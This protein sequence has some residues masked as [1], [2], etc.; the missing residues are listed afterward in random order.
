VVDVDGNEYLDVLNNYTALVHGHAFGPIVDALARAARDGSVHPAPH[1][2][3]LRLA[4]TITQRYPAAELV[5]FTN[6][7]T[8][9]AV[10]AA[11][12]A[13]RATGRQRI[14]MFEG[15]YHGTAPDFVGETADTIRVPYNDLDAVSAV[16]DNRVAAVFAEPFLGS[17]G[18]IAAA[19]GFLRGVEALARSAGAVFVLDEVQSLRSA[20][21]G[22][23]GALGLRPDLLLMGKLIG[24]GLP[25]GA[26]VGRGELLE[27]TAAARRDSL[28]HS[29]TFNG[30]VLT[31]AA[32]EESLRFLDASA[33]ERLNGCAGRLEA[34]IV[35]AADKSG[36]AIETTRSG[37]IIQVHTSGAGRNTDP[38]MAAAL[39][40]A[41]LLE[42][43]YAAPRGMLN[44]STALGEEELRRVADGYRGAFARL[45][46]L[47]EG[48]GAT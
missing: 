44:L 13:R 16:L 35:T 46:A 27:L 7:G 31:C 36:V 34:D 33:I 32:G 3:Q 30:N 9:A 2:R 20:Y 47:R 40:L 6:S 45:G 17:G 12:I 39:H 41:L 26:V 1:A 37:S 42:G 28:L 25:V 18:V 29:G 10:L 15:G 38:T 22:V 48:I 11:R 14:V 4:Q 19:E 43:V 5:R 21:A 23:H 8:E 24:G